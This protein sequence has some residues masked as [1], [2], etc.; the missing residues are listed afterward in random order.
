MRLV[1]RL[2]LC[3]LMLLPTNIF[4][5]N[6]QNKA[7]IRLYEQTSATSPMVERDY[8]PEPGLYSTDTL[9]SGFPESWIRRS[10][11]VYDS[12]TNAFYVGTTEVGTGTASI[13]RITFNSAAQL[14]TE[15]VR[16]GL[17]PIWDMT[18]IVNGTDVYLAYIVHTPN[19]TQGQAAGVNTS[20]GINFELL[21]IKSSAGILSNQ[22]PVA[23]AFA[24][25]LSGA[26]S[27]Y[28]KIAS[29]TNPLDSNRPVLFLAISKANQK[30][31]SS[32]TNSCLRA[33]QFNSGTLTELT[34]AASALNFSDLV[35]NRLDDMFW[36]STLNTLYINAEQTA[37]GASQLGILKFQ[38][39]SATQLTI[40]K[41]LTGSVI[42]PNMA[43]S[44]KA[45]TFSST[46]N[47]YMIIN[48]SEFRTSTNASIRMNSVFALPVV[49]TG[50]TAGKIGSTI[51]EGTAATSAT[52]TWSSTQN[53]K[54]L[55]GNGPVFVAGGTDNPGASITGLIVSPVYNSNTKVDVFVAMAGDTPD[56]KGIF[57]S[58]GT[59]T[60]GV[61][62]SWS[63]WT[64]IPHTAH[65]KISCMSLANASSANSSD[66]AWILWYLAEGSD[67]RNIIQMTRVDGADIAGIALESSKITT[68]ITGIQLRPELRYFPNPLGNNGRLI[69]PLANF[70]KMEQTTR[71]SWLR[72][73][74]TAFGL[75]ASSVETFYVGCTEPGAADRSIVKVTVGGGNIIQVTPLAPPTVTSY[76]NTF[77][78]QTG[79]TINPLYNAAI[80][81][82]VPML[83]ATGK[84]TK[85]AVILHTG[86]PA[87]RA[88][89]TQRPARMTPSGG[90][91][92][93]FIE[94][95]TAGLTIRESN[96][97]LDGTNAFMTA[98]NPSRVMLMESAY[99]N[100]GSILFA[101]IADASTDI[102]NF[103][104]TSTGNNVLR[105][106][107]TTLTPAT[108]GATKFPVLPAPSRPIVDLQSMHW[109]PGMRILFLGGLRPGDGT[110]ATKE[111]A[112]FTAT[113][114]A[115]NQPNIKNSFATSTFGIPDFKHVFN[116][117]TMQ[118][119]DGSAQNYLLI[120]GGL[121]SAQTLASSLDVG[122]VFALPLVTATGFVAKSGNYTL[123]TTNETT[124]WSQLTDPRY[125]VGRTPL[126]TLLNQAT[127][128]LITQL[129]ASGPSAFASVYQS[130]VYQGQAIAMAGNFSDWNP[131]TLLPVTANQPIG[132]FGLGATNIF[133]TTGTQNLWTNKI[134]VA[135]SGAATGF[136][137]S[138]DISATIIN[139]TQYIRRRT[140]GGS[141][142]GTFFTV[143]DSGGGADTIQTTI[144]GGTAQNLT[145]TGAAPDISAIQG[146]NGI[147]DI[148]TVQDTLFVV[149]RTVSATPGGN[150]IYEIDLATGAVSPSHATATAGK[151]FLLLGAGSEST[152]SQR[153]L[154]FALEQLNSKTFINESDIA[155]A[156]MRIFD[157]TNMS[158]V[159][160]FSLNAA[161]LNAKDF[162]SIEDIWWDESLEVLYLALRMNLD[163][164]V[165]GQSDLGVAA[166]QWNSGTSN[167]VFAGMLDNTTAVNAI[168]FKHVTKVRTMHTQDSSGNSAHA[169]LIMNAAAVA[170]HAAAGAQDFRNIYA[171]PIVVDVPPASTTRGRFSTM[172][173]TN[174]V[175]NGTSDTVSNI[176]G[177]SNTE[178]G[179]LTPGLATHYIE[180]RLRVGGAPLPCDAVAEITDILVQ[181][182]SVYVSVANPPISPVVPSISNLNVRKNRGV[183]VSH[184]QMDSTGALT[185]WSAW[186]RAPST[187]NKDIVGISYD[188]ATD[189]M[190]FQDTTGAISQSTWSNTGAGSPL[191]DFMTHVTADL[192]GGINSALSK[193]IVGTTA[194]NILV[195]GGTGKIVIAHLGDTNNLPATFTA[196]ASTY[197]VVDVSSVDSNPITSLALT[198]GPTGWLAF[199]SRG[200]I[201]VL[202]DPVT[203]L[204]WTGAPITVNDLAGSNYAFTQIFVGEVKKIKFISPTDII[205]ALPQSIV[206]IRLS[207]NSLV[208][209]ATTGPQVVASVSF[210][211]IVTDFDTLKYDND[212]LA[213]TA[214]GL[215][216][217]KLD[218]TGGLTL[219]T[220]TLLQVFGPII[221][222]VIAQS[223][224]PVPGT[225]H[226]YT[227]HF[228]AS[229]IITQ[230]SVHY[231]FPI[232][233]SSSGTVT[234][235]MS[236]LEVVQ[237]LGSF[238]TGMSVNGTTI[239]YTTNQSGG[240]ITIN[241]SST[242]VATS[243]GIMLPSII[244]PYGVSLRPGTSPAVKS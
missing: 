164:F 25:D 205:A 158:L 43:H 161:P 244:T 41:A 229:N 63:N 225:D 108:L 217:V 114:S 17:D 219:Q 12:N 189:S 83:D 61:L 80:W 29:G 99:I 212:I 172:A 74:T 81:D 168:G 200:G 53:A 116:A 208:A 39:S 152:G 207:A 84:I 151:N 15:T 194:Q 49:K 166:L 167:F 36:D 222:I 52:A 38:F 124:T 193:E 213:V 133:F 105:V 174:T 237:D 231:K 20:G 22:T 96:P 176:W 211:E 129:S 30:N 234:P 132:G 92:I 70:D 186:Q 104:G 77:S 202:R 55:V 243:S 94:D 139:S 146:T 185:G 89:I 122:R 93:Y 147:W 136:A 241:G 1:H 227:A 171:M 100:N 16:T 177:L 209:G 110:A 7:G 169:Y 11:C 65:Q 97:I 57:V 119:Q 159:R 107:L 106:F 6:Q 111:L 18:T 37:E 85:L 149:P 201:S 2:L 155:T 125:S 221:Q 153:P 72:R 68:D 44:L 121:N 178:G 150:T 62:T 73:R 235:L 228:L 135:I 46:T 143:K 9:D 188:P 75:D 40:D 203:G 187:Y 226:Y 216:K 69:D 19:L 195:A 91:R 115:S 148:T 28:L 196:S 182:T 26:F 8:A 24:V 120:Q 98:G 154:I 51:S 54:R 32:S 214:I 123:P 95:L 101:S 60:S 58:T 145:L 242:T 48:G 112:L 67:K 199:A 76:L 117:T 102:I 233:V 206:R 210:N 127:D 240:K 71:G 59:L 160:D 13:R 87:Q 118:T 66:A 10:T 239:E 179:Q 113:V 21:K 220:K 180:A 141:D 156:N 232:F 130:G 191:Q 90:T 140:A 34:T 78:A 157:A 128:P 88:A 35:W 184:A 42:C 175:F 23:S 86:G 31:A 162:Q 198:T 137:T 238:Y 163:T 3:L 14:V 56:T 109:D 204:G 5:T 215:Y 170:G 50:A 27:R 144:P 4:G 79:K 134:R 236:Q 47:S 33:Y 197:K 45:R 142:N 138:P 230:Q 223:A 218:Q 224:P 64:L 181:G 103:D 131:W 190:I 173:D 82:I 183:Y 165:D 126:K 192:S